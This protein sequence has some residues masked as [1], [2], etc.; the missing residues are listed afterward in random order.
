M[1]DRT[2]EGEGTNALDEGPRGQRVHGVSREGFEMCETIV[3]A[4][5]R[6]GHIA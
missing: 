6:V 2:F 4:S 1:S 5:E 3:R